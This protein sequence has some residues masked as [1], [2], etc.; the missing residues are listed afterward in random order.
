[1]L[2]M[3]RFLCSRLRFA[4]LAGYLLVSKIFIPFVREYQLLQ[5]CN[6][7]VKV[8]GGSSKFSNFTFMTFS[9]AAEEVMFKTNDTPRL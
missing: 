1:M 5:G 4:T 8:L 7:G 9:S 3:I 6:I 2:R